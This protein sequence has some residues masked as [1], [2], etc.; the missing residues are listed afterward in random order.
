M[1]V[2]VT[3]CPTCYSYLCVSGNVPWLQQ[4]SLSPQDRDLEAA[5]L[6]LQV[7]SSNVKNKVNK[8]F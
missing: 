7:K 6:N 1:Y 2:A 5:S 4:P 3:Y 8:E